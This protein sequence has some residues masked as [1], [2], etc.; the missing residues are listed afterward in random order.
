M[1]EATKGKFDEVLSGV[2][3]LKEIG[4]HKPE[5]DTATRLKR[6]W[7]TITAGTNVAH[8]AGGAAL[9]VVGPGTVDMARGVAAG[10]PGSMGEATGALLT[11]P[12]LKGAGRVLGKVAPK[13]P[14]ATEGVRLSPLQ[15]GETGLVGQ[16]E[17]ALRQSVGASSL[18]KAFDKG[19][20]AELST[21]ADNL[22]RNVSNVSKQT[23]EQFGKT[24]QTAQKAAKD[25]AQAEVTTAY[26]Q[27]MRPLVD[28]AGKDG[29]VSTKMLK[30]VADR[31]VKE[32][33]GPAGIGGQELL[34]P[35]KK[36]KKL[37]AKIDF[38]L[39]KQVRSRLMDRV[40]A[41]TEAKQISKTAAGAMEKGL[42]EAVDTAMERAAKKGGFLEEWR[43]ANSK[44]AEFQKEWNSRS[45]R[46]LAKA[47]PSEIA[48]VLKGAT[49]EELKLA[50]KLM[51]AEALDAAG[52]HMLEQWIAGASEGKGLTGGERISGAKLQT[53]LA[54]MGLDR[55][56]TVLGPDK[57]AE[58]RK[59]TEQVKSTQPRADAAITGRRIGSA[60]N[61]SLV[62]GAS[63]GILSGDI[64]GTLTGTG[65]AIIAQRLLAKALLRQ[66]GTGTALARMVNAMEKAGNTASSPALRVPATALAKILQKQAEEDELAD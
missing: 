14:V 44:H 45:M 38:E 56:E 63:Y 4:G 3:K 64:A 15:A 26:D 39:M 53:G 36:L 18:F 55:L 66:R 11:G 12:M 37:P 32:L 41:V 1:A 21:A 10:D 6:V 24:W 62:L 40:R 46:S 8:S 35:L 52:A 23:G 17:A 2:Q 42:V 29:M 47:Q 13:A 25:A 34:A 50:K 65:G 60:L 5:D 22:V 19:Q 28:A 58:V 30:G 31:M 49:V 61:T 16:T 57:L 27:T 9:P 20:V 7:D 33:K 48:D 43:E 51:P 54:R 59:F